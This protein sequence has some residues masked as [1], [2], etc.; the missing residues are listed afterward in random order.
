MLNSYPMVAAG[1]GSPL[2]NPTLIIAAV[3]GHFKRFFAHHVHMMN[4]SFFDVL[5][6]GFGG[7]RAS[8]CRGR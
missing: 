2:N 3:G 4:R 5:L 8:G 6:G 1:I 7:L